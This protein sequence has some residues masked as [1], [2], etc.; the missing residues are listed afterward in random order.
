[1]QPAA[2]KTKKRW[3]L[4][5]LNVAVSVVLLYLL[6]RPMDMMAVADI[7]GRLPIMAIAVALTLIV[8]QTVVLGL[9]WWLTLFAF[10]GVTADTA[11]ALSLAFGVALLAASLP[12]CVFWMTWRNVATGTAP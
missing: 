12:G 10:A 5:L 6:L 8:V 11:L 3:F 4:A 1:M 2:A 9:R 7:L